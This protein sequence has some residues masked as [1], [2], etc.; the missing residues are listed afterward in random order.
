MVPK[1]LSD[2]DKSAYAVPCVMYHTRSKAHH[3]SKFC[4]ECKG[5]LRSAE[6]ETKINWP[7]AKDN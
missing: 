6:I 7:L 1:T 4:K 3:R 2:P 5:K